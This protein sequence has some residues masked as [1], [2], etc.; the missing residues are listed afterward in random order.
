MC[1]ITAFFYKLS[2]YQKYMKKKKRKTL[3]QNTELSN[4]RVQSWAQLTN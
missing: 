1:D 2:I 4:L 3:Q